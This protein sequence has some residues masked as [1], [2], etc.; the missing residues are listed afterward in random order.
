MTPGSGY[1]GMPGGQAARSGDGSQ[2]LTGL[3][4]LGEG[5]SKELLEEAKDQGI[6]VLVMF[7]VDVNQNFKTKFVNNDTKIE[8][9]DVRRGV[10]LKRTRPLNNIQVQKARAEDDND[11]EDPVKITLDSLFEDL[12]AEAEDGLKLRDF[13]EAI[14]PEHVKSR[15]AAILTDDQLERLPVLAEIKFYHSRGLLDDATLTKSFQK[16]LGELDGAK[17]SEGKEEER[18]EVVESLLPRE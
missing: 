9:W 11:D 7:E 15:V 13:P 12:S 8:V 1:P 10:S 18:L 4:V 16:V 6:D 17:L 3:V 2:L 14:R 5:T